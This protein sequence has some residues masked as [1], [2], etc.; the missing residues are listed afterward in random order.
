M[1]RYNLP[2]NI[3]VDVTGIDLQFGAVVGLSVDTPLP[4]KFAGTTN[5]IGIINVLPFITANYDTTQIISTEPGTHYVVLGIELGIVSIVSYRLKMTMA[6]HT[7][8]RTFSFS[9]LS[10]QY[11][12]IAFNVD[13]SG[14]VTIIGS[15][16]IAPG[17]QPITP[18]GISTTFNTNDLFELSAGAM[19]ETIT[20]MMELMI[21][22]MMMSMM[23][24]MITGMMASIGGAFGG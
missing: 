19:S 8:D 22:M 1:V 11:I 20:A 18:T 15:G 2:V 5:A 7:I 4:N 17:G 10:K 16:T 14:A 6:G 23:M 24:N 13:N 21:P 3:H 9:E 12:Y